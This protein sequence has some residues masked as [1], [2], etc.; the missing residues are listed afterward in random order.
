M[1]ARDSKTLGE[2]G[3][4]ATRVQWN[5]SRTRILPK[6]WKNVYFIL[7]TRARQVYYIS[8]L[9]SLFVFLL[10][11]AR[12]SHY[13]ALPGIPWYVILRKVGV[14]AESCVP[15][16]HIKLLRIGATV[17]VVEVAITLNLMCIGHRSVNA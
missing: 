6:S 9:W 17:N 11:D 14:T 12:S 3:V 16:R 8:P 5:A 7:H 1:D 4:W 15:S 2:F 13:T 10:L